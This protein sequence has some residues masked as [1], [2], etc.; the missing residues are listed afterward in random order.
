MSTFVCE[1][2]GANYRDEHPSFWVDNGKPDR[3]DVHP[4]YNHDF[5]L[6][7]VA[8]EKLCNISDTSDPA[9]RDFEYYFCGMRLASKGYY[10]TPRTIF[11]SLAVNSPHPSVRRLGQKAAMWI[12]DRLPSCAE[13]NPYNKDHSFDHLI[14]S[15][16]LFLAPKP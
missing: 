5:S 16:D 10:F 13:I 4:S 15:R 11:A 7:A 12:L 1:L 9:D 8:A 6:P 3:P 14:K 2:L